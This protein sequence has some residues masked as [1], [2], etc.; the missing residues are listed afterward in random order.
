MTLRSAESEHP[1]LISRDIVFEVFQPVWPPYLN[2]MD[3]QRDGRRA[4]ASKG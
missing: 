2:T 4:W 1:V 3:K